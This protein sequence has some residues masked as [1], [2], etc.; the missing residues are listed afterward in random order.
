MSITEFA[1]RA[2]VSRQAIYKAFA[3]GRIVKDGPQID[4][5]LQLNME[6]LL[7][8]NPTVNR[9]VSNSLPPS[10]RPSVSSGVVDVVSDQPMTPRAIQDLEKARQQAMHWALRNAKERGLLIDRS[11]VSLVIDITDTEH[12]RML[13]DVP[14]SV[15]RTAYDMARS[16]VAREELID[17]IR[18]EMSGVLKRWKRQ[19]AKQMK[20]YCD[21]M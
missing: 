15:A 13:S 19:V 10:S 14:E 1:K 9:Q 20:T 12:R 8:S 6:Y 3:T 7:A 18:S 11:L 16:G 2:G 17:A 4:E 5:T 21:D